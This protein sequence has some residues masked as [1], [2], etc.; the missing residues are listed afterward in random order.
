[1]CKSLCLQPSGWSL[2]LPSFSGFILFTTFSPLLSL[3]SHLYLSLS[4]P[5]SIPCTCSGTCLSCQTKMVAKSIPGLDHARLRM[6]LYHAI[7]DLEKK[8][9]SSSGYQCH[10]LLKMMRNKDYGIVI[11]GLNVSRKFLEKSTVSC[12][13]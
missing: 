9:R 8:H 13:V 3:P 4:L 7:M 2:T 12:G 11:D 1:M 10:G 6:S 5:L